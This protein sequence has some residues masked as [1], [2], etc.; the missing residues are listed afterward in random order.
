MHQ[1]IQRGKVAMKIAVLFLFTFFLLGCQNDSS[2][3]AFGVK[4]KAGEQT[5][6]TINSEGN[7][8][9]YYEYLPKS[10]NNEKW[11]LIFYWNGA[12]A[13][14]GNGKDEITNLLMQGLPEFIHQGKHYPAIIISG[15]LPDWQNDDISDFVNYILKRY[16]NVVDKKRVYMTGFSAGGGVTLRYFKDHPDT[17]AAIIPVSP[18]AHP[19]KDGELNE[20]HGQVDS[21]FFHNSGDMK[22]EIWRSNQWHHALKQVGGD[23]K[24]TRPDLDS[25]YA[26]Q[27]AYSAQ[28]TWDWL[29][30]KSKQDQ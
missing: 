1:V 15:M 18:A 21:W 17:L 27:A 14:A 6:I 24:I 7:P 2:S 3:M 16:E 10:F 11:P 13:I 19:P 25:H 20:K 29:F 9:A 5:P 22:V 12:N 30:S 8:F 26:W 28:E 23:R 4:G